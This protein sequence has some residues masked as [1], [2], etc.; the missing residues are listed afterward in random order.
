VQDPHCVAVEHDLHRRRHLVLYE[1]FLGKGP[2]GLGR[3]LGRA[4]GRTLGSLQSAVTLLNLTCVS[5][6]RGTTVL[7]FRQRVSKEEP[8][9][10]VSNLLKQITEEALYGV[11]EFS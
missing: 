7:P 1:E 11:R 6:S 3:T 9:F 2:V 10:G 5:I 4:L 8:V